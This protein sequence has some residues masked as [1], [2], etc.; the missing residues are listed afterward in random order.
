M[1]DMDR[2][3]RQLSNGIKVMKIGAS[4]KYHKNAHLAIVANRRMIP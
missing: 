4:K 3:G 2:G 1:L